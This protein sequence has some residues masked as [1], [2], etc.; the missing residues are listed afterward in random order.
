MAVVP[1]RWSQRFLPTCPL[2]LPR[3]VGQWRDFEFSRMRA[4]STQDAATITILPRTSTS[5]FVARSTY[6]TP[7]ARPSPS[8]STSRATAFVRSSRFPVFSAGGSRKYGVEKND[9]V[10][11]PSVQLPQ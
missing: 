4:D 9:P 3:P 10:S 5:C 6:A 2:E 8:T 11:Q 7:R 1:Y